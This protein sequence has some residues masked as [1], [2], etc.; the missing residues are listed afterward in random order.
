MPASTLQIDLGPFLPA[1]DVKAQP[2]DIIEF[3]RILSSH[4]AIYVGDGDVIHVTG[5]ETQEIPDSEIALVQRAPITVVAGDSV[6][7]VNNKSLRAKERN[8][9]P[10]HN[11]IV[12]RKALSKV[13]GF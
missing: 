6:C 13:S 5:T 10:F 11:E 8:L 4:F 2:G 9:I 12:V 7:R 3:D 1:S